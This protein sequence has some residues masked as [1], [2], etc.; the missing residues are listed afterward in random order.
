MN[1]A[2]MGFGT[3]GS[4]VY[5]IVKENQQILA[6]KA[7]EEI[8]IKHV[9]DLREFPGH[10]VE[11]VLTH[12]IDDILQDETVGVVVEVMGG[13]GA[14]YTFVKAALEA[15]KHVVTSNKALIAAKGAELMEIA[16]QK[17]VS[18]LF[19]AS[20]GGGIPILRTLNESLVADRIE[21]IVGILNGT[22][23]YILTEMTQRGAAFDAVLKEAQQLGYA[24]ADPTADVEGHDACRKIA[25]LSTLAYGKTVD[26]EEIYTE[27]ITKITEKDIA[28]GKML[29][30]VVKLVGVSR[31]LA[32]GVS[33]MVYPILLAKTHPL[34][35]VSGA[36][37]AIF[38][39]GNMLGDT[40]YYGSGAGSLPT[41]SAVLS[42]VVNVVRQK[43][44]I[45]I[46]WD[47]AGKQEILPLYEVPTSALIRIAAKEQAQ[48]KEMALSL[49][50]GGKIIDLAEADDE[51]AVLTGME[52]EASLA[53]K[54]Q[55]LKEHYEVRNRIRTEAA[56]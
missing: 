19:E 5:T 15:G 52:T 30:C 21:E 41:A 29:D 12:Q 49:F 20:V 45:H 10:P 4:G 26:F 3:V 47:T 1:I 25:I 54:I 22:T 32:E 38:V 37:N 35:G 18:L 34:S 17:N 31:N 46:D 11:E 40:M 50:A 14:A 6:K 8:L 7:G 16:R 9:L 53:E 43:Q 55:S 33:A 28:Y 13:T 42:D 2:V 48:A 23:N 51:F 24:E 39:K 56:L 44:H 36:F 27:G